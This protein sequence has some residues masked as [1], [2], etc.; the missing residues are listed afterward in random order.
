[1]EKIKALAKGQRST[2]MDSHAKV[3]NIESSFHHLI[4]KATK[5]HS[6]VRLQIPETLISGFSF[7]SQCLMYT[8]EFGYIRTKSSVS[9]SIMFQFF[10]ICWN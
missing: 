1:M 10:E 9:S 5:T 2:L 7:E 8:D 6:K 4:Y 3:C